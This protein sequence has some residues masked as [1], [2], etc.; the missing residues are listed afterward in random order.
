MNS[1]GA[2]AVRLTQELI[3]INTSNPGGSERPAASL[4]ADELHGMA[5][6]LRWFEP[7][8]GRTS[9]VARVPGIDRTLPPLLVH[10]HLDVVPAIESEWSRD[11]FGGEI[12]DGCIWGRGAVDMKGSIATTLS[13]LRSLQRAATAPRRDLVVAF[14]AD[15]EAGGQL[16]AGHVISEAAELFAGCTAAIGEVGGFG[17][18]LNEAHRAYFVATAE[19]GVWWTRLTAHGRSGHGSMVNSN[20][21]ILTLANDVLQ[22]STAFSA[23]ERS[24]TPTTRA[25]VAA[26][27]DALGLPDAPL[28]Q[29]LGA[30][31]PMRRMLT[32]GLCNTVNPTQ[33]DAGYKSN[34]IPASASAVLDGRFVPGGAEAIRERVTSL[35]S[36]SADLETIYIGDAVEADLAHPLLGAIAS[37]LLADDASAV[38]VPY[39][40]TAFT[41]AKWISQ[42]GVPC[43][44]FSPMQ[45]PDDFD[46][47]AM[48][49]GV[50]ERAPTSALDFGTRVLEHLFLH[51]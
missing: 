8:P 12:E 14:F 20:N 5:T 38:V 23:D 4:V 28:E 45:L 18:S 21:A 46:F 22:I 34:V 26:L 44:G 25:T 2:D 1:G 47:P 24:L 13:A 48:F 19:K 43:Y 37:A 9:V 10:A 15:E 42:L 30:I 40:S 32:A 29:M 7:E 16:G 33:L 11:P 36:P 41:D 49:H 50:D 39:M 31:E 35:V 27:Q 6:D 51:F 17:Y 3:R